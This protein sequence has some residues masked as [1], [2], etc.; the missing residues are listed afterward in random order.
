MPNENSAVVKIIAQK[1]KEYN[2]L[3]TRYKK[4]GVKLLALSGKH[5]TL[6]EVHEKTLRNE[7]NLTDKLKEE[8]REIVED[9][10]SCRKY[11]GAPHYK[12]NINIVQFKEIMEKWEGKK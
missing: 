7:Y 6:M 8:R 5:K 12:L 2:D 11:G 9:L 3:D 4:L 1:T 10:V